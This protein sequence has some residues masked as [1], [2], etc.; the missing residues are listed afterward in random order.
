M[1]K[2]I[3]MLSAFVMASATLFAQVDRTKRPEAGP[4][5]APEIGK[6]ESFTLKNGL[7]VFVVENHKLPSIAMSLVLDI[8]PI[9]EGSKA[10]YVGL[11]G[12]LMGRGTT[13]KSKEVFD[14]EVD[15]MGASF[16][17]GST[18]VS[19][20]GLSKYTAK[21]MELMGDAIMNPAFTQEE[22]DKAIEQTLSGLKSNQDDAEAIMGNVYGAL[23]YGKQ[24]PYGEIMT[25]ATVNTIT[26]ADCKAY[27]ATYFK[28]NVAYLA[29]V[30]DISLK[31][32]KK[33][34]K[35]YFGSWKAG[36][37]PKHTYPLPT[38]V[39]KSMVAFVDR[40]AS[41]Q[42][43]IRIGN[44]I[45]LKPGDA[46]IEPL[47]VLNQILGGGS[48][49]RLFLNL[50]ESKGYTY[51]AYSSFGTD[52]LVSSYYSF[53]QVRNEVTNEAI[54]EFLFELNSIREGEVS[55]VEMQKAKASISGSFGR[56]LE[57]PATLATFAL[58]TAKDGLPADY[59][60]NYLVRLD[61]VT[62]E[63]VMR[64]AQKYITTDNLLIT[65]VG[66]GQQVAPT[67]TE[68]GAI[69]YFDADANP[70][71]APSFL[72]MP[73]GVTAA[74]VV[75][76]YL[77]AVGGKDKLSK[78]VAYQMV[79][80]ATMQGLPAPLE[81]I[82][83]KRV[84]DYLL[85]SQSIPGMFSQ[86]TLY[87]KGK[88]TKMGMENGDLE[89][90]ELEEAKRE[91]SVAFEE[92]NYLTPAYTITL[93]GQTKM[94]GKDVYQLLVKNAAGEERTEY[95]DVATGLKLREEES[96]E[97]PQGPM[98]STKDIE[99]Y[100]DFDG[101]KI[102]SKFTQT[103]GPQVLKVSLKSFKINKDVPVSMFK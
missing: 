34:T 18:N 41:V 69:S 25:E 19:A 47:R 81:V 48:M 80:E 52:D 76:N 7:K 49:G 10:G 8:D 29:I 79:M 91:A 64:V 54:Q 45:V 53:A 12:E 5:R 82:V 26:V 55:D 62:K 9:A 6:Y 46:D 50:R 56:S 86:K 85:S 67:L 31:E 72:T 93:Q 97:T 61:A 44:P 51:G 21:L 90:A 89:G 65:V 4:P 38:G 73:V 13:T 42:S 2:Y 33:L 98:S 87:V 59:Y 1:R 3:F 58:N 103:A 24:H 99:E 78:I 95:Y 39:K 43:V 32:A 36:E 57:S 68:Y 63:D 35:K 88:G 40:P 30:G 71:T 11:A 20:R 84:P 92:M 15:N 102:P 23:I 37:V 70:T 94:A 100:K 96:E 66:K 83:A 16:G 77:K 22:F 74:D 14:L 101:V 75:N 60:Q 17:T 28:P 27:H